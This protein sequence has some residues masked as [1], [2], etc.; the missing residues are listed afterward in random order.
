MASSMAQLPRI[1]GH[2]GGRKAEAIAV[3]WLESGWF[4]EGSI[5]LFVR[6]LDEPGRMVWVDKDSFFADHETTER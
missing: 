6:Y 1:Q 3:R 5:Q 4:N 2:Q